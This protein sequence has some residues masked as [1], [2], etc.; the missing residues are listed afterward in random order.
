VPRLILDQ[1]KRSETQILNESPPF[2]CISC[3]EPFTTRAIVELMTERLRDNPFFQGDE[4]NK[5]RQCPDCRARF[6]V[7]DQL[8]RQGPKGDAGV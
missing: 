8:Q 6:N 5:L 1:K 7:I 2:H 4:V 3:G